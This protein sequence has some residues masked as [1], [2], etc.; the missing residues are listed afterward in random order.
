[1]WRPPSA[2]GEAGWWCPL[3]A[4]GEVGQGGPARPVGSEPPAQQQPQAT[5]TLALLTPF[6]QCVI[7]RPTPPYNNLLLS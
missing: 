3:G 4:G 6:I 2:G 1:M 7:A 5:R